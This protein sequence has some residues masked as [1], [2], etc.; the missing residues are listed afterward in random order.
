MIEYPKI[1]FQDMHYYSAPVKKDSPK[2]LDEVD[3]ELLNAYE[4][5]GIPLDE[6]K[7]LAGVAVD[8]IFDS[9]SIATTFQEELSKHGIIFCS[10]SDALQNYP[11]L[12]KKYLGRVV[13]YTDKFYAC[14]NGA[15]FSDG[16]FCYVPKGVTCPL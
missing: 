9:V 12:I 14:L 4:K 10:F 1:D 11:D 16:S 13:P 15:V 6:Q 8:A 3:P 7:R 2:S 5:L